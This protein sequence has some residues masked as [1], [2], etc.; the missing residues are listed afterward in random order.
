MENI[1][2]GI[3][4]QSPVREPSGEWAGVGPRGSPLPES[5]DCGCLSM[6]DAPSC[7]W[8][9]YPEQEEKKEEGREEEEG[10]RRRGRRGREE[11]GG[12]NRRTMIMTEHPPCD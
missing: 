6:M 5:S 4:S 1:L 10:E 9:F 3:S 11:G 12:E 7:P 2:E 8:I